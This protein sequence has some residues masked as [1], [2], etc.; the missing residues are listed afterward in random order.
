MS[1]VIV[2]F[3]NFKTPRHQST[4]PFL[5]VKNTNIFLIRKGRVIPKRTKRRKRNEYDKGKGLFLC[6]ISK[7][8]YHE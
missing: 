1:P 8:E 3:V 5:S 7:A 6:R 4:V 2:L